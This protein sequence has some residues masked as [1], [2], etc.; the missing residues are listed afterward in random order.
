MLTKLPWYP[1][2]QL[3]GNMKGREGL[4]TGIGV[5]TSFFLTQY[6]CSV[7]IAVQ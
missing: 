4:E 6:N 7:V 3:H 1:R 5:D 2:K